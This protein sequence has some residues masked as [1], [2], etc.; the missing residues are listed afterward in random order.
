MSSR[1][2]DNWIKDTDD[3]YKERIHASKRDQVKTLV[4]TGLQTSLIKENKKESLIKDTD[5]RESLINSE[6]PKKSAKKSVQDKQQTSNSKRDS[7]TKNDSNKKELEK[8]RNTDKD[9]KE[10]ISETKKETKKQDGIKKNS[11]N[12][13]SIRER[14][15][16]NMKQLVRFTGDQVGTEIKEETGL[17]E[18][19]IGEAEQ[20][21]SHVRATKEGVKTTA[22]MLGKS[23]KTTVKVAKT[24]VWVV[25]NRKRIATATKQNITNAFKMISKFIANPLV[26]IKGAGIGLIVIAICSI[27][28]IVAVTVSSMISSFTIKTEEAELTKT[29]SYL[30]ELDTDATLKIRSG[31]NE[32]EVNG[33]YSS[34]EKVDIYTNIDVVLAYMD[35]VYGDYK[36]DRNLPGRGVTAQSELSTLYQQLISQSTK[37][38][39]DSLTIQEV[40]DFMNKEKKDKDLEEQL[41]AMAEAGQYSSLEELGNPFPENEQV[42][43]KQ[44]FGYYV[45]EN[46][47][48]ESKGIT[49]QSD[50][51]KAV[52]APMSGVIIVSKNGA[53]ITKGKQTV[54]LSNIDST[55][56]NR[57]E[58]KKGQDIGKTTGENNLEIEYSKAGVTVNPGFYFPNVQY[59][60]FTN[61]GYSSMGS[62][63]DE[64]LFRMLITT[65]CNAFSMKAD[66]I[67]AEAKKAGVSPVIFAAIMIH[68]SSWGTSRAI[69]EHNNPSGQM[70]SSGLIHYNSLDEGIEAT[71]KTLHN[72]IIERKLQTVE[73]LGSVYCPIGAAND[74][75]G[76]N[77]NW[78]PAIKVFMTQLGGSPEMSLLW[79][80]GSGKAGKMLEFANS[81]YGKG[82]IYTQSGS[83]GTFPYHD[84]SSFVIKAMQEAG[85]SVGMGN[86]ETLFGLEGTLLQP[87]SRD[88]V[89]AGDIFVWGNKSNS[90]GDL[91]HTGIFMDDGGKTIIHCSTAANQNGNVIKTPFEGYYGSPNLAPVYFYRVN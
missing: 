22:H 20:T 82:V 72:L 89:K 15:K 81:L 35:G 74:P 90:S 4:K 57:S 76:L 33:A 50:K 19:L 65:K 67:L 54:S 46:K 78:V 91:G 8:K 41:S 28:L 16:G 71:G 42:M 11:K 24:P 23:A 68:E 27:L 55:V 40:T 31:T 60:Q 45:K 17:N 30:T 43:V 63:F 52:H 51:G 38:G 3:K 48:A 80:E 47:K 25:R 61:Y 79:S 32:L 64:A 85:I 10:K 7:K 66:K 88:Q 86:T 44:R 59:L 2:S 70:T 9:S 6:V 49:I 5:K 87:I 58:V 13:K 84:C 53:S 75:L 77:K 1:K 14:S 21:I 39:K 12:K 36:L 29:W 37:D 73:A 18:T 62:G 83:R 56:T 69:M 34:R 26:V